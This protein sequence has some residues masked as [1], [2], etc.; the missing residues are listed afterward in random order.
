MAVETGRVNLELRPIVLDELA[1]YERADEYGF[2]IRYDADDDRHAWSGAELDRTVAVFEGDEIVAT[3]RNY[4]LELTLPGGAVIPTSAVSW[5]SVRPTHRRRGILTR[6][7]TYLLEEGAQRGENVSMLTASEG[8]IYARFGY[9]VATR[10]LAIEMARNA[11]AF[12]APVH[13]GRVRMIE[14][15]E[16]LK[17]APELFDRV[18]LQ[19]TGAVS[20]PAVWWL[21][22][23]GQKEFVKYRFDVVYEVDGR[24]EGFAI[25][26][27]DGTWANGVPDRTVAVH[28]LVA[29]T[30]EAEAALWQHL[31]GIDLTNRVTH[32]VVAPDTELPWRLRDSRQVRT[33]AL[34]DWLW[35]RPVDVPGLLGLRRYASAERMVLEVR[36]DMRSDGAAAGRFLLEG[37]PDGATCART[38]ATPDLVLDVGALGSISLGGITAS[39]L[40][41]ADQVEEQTP[42][43]LAAADRMFA[44]DRAPFA[45]TWF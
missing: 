19:R 44:A 4:S 16:S 29:A 11:I 35:V 39:L 41:R 37:G 31:C 43:A 21:D 38:E 1:A 8:G 10:V 36:D 30:P 3:G 22:A 14:P 2:G 40:A 42:G 28:D 12:A 33:T 17:I 9:G 27:V 15:E 13:R 23:W 18:R 20:R 34:R 7:M 45:F 26:G 24:V 32:S 5:I 6:V 25:Y